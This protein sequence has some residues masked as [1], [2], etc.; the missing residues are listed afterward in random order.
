MKQ[1]IEEQRKFF[2]TNITKN[3]AFRIEQLKKLKR[4]LQVN[5][6]LFYEAIY[7]DFKNQNLILIQVSYLCSIKKLMR[8]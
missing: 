1:I 8:Q 3:I 7:S 2:H 4:I 5:E 6:Q